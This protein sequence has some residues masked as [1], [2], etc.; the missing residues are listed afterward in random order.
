MSTVFF[1][2]PLVLFNKESITKL[3]PNP[4]SSVEERVNASARF[5]LFATCGLY[6]YTRN[7]RVFAIALFAFGIL[8]IM[9]NKKETSRGV[10]EVSNCHLPTPD[11]PMANFL[12]P[13]WNTPRKPACDYQTV[14]PLVNDYVSNRFLPGNTRSR[15]PLPEQQ[16]YASERQW[17]MNPARDNPNS[18]ME[19]A[20]FCYGKKFQPTCRDTPEM[21]DP[22]ARGAQLEAFAGLDPAGTG[23]MHGGGA[24]KYS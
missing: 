16:R 11:N 1:K 15:A 19:F 24:I 17:I 6:L 18:Q 22:N 13:E 4:N 23:R 20:E 14:K 9:Y 10:N 3:W 8:Y 12:Q 7:V 21:C 5:V 2:D